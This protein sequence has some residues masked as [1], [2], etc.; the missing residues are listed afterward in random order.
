VLSRNQHRLDQPAEDHVVFAPF[1]LSSS[2]VGPPEI[3]WAGMLSS[4]V[5]CPRGEVPNVGVPARLALGMT[6]A[7]QQQIVAGIPAA[8]GS[9]GDLR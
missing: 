2:G 8:A 1:I 7:G 6:V 5:V 3:V 9:A 4:M